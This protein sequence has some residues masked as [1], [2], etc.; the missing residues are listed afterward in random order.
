MK[1][2]EILDN[3]WIKTNH[4]ELRKSHSINFVLWAHNERPMGDDG[5]IED[6]V[7]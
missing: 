5:P 4:L 3:R 6:F 1:L 2:N 7:H